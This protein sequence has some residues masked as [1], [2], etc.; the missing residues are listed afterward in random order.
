MLVASVIKTYA[1]YPSPFWHQDQLN[2][3]GVLDTGPVIVTF[4]NSPPSGT[5]RRLDGF[6]KGERADTSARRSRAERREA[7]IGCF[8]RHLGPAADHPE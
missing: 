2:G 6:L 4:D 7:V 1:I 3:Q 8:V 5:P